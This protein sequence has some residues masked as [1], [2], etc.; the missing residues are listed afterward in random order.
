MFIGDGRNPFGLFKGEDGG[1]D[2]LFYI[3]FEGHADHH[4]AN[5]QNDR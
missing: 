2:T 4:Q 3:D 1:T 5:Y